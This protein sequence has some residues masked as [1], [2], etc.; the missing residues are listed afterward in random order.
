MPKIPIDYTSIFIGQLDRATDEEAVKERFGNY[1]MIVGVQVFA[2]A[3]GVGKK[4]AGG[5]A[6]VKFEGRDGASRAVKAE[7]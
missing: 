4:A 3:G 2:K 1:G 7:V 5:F 6:F